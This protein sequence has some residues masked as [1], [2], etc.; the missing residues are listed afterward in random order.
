MEDGRRGDTHIL[1]MAMKDDRMPSHIRLDFVKK[2]YGIL[3]AMLMVS[4]LI[5]SPFVFNTEST[6][7]VMRNY[8]WIQG[9]CVVI[10]LAHN[11]VNMAIAFEQ[12]CGGGACTR[13]Y[14]KMF[15]TTPWNYIFLFTYAA[16]FGVVLGIVCTQYKASSVGLVF[17]LTAG[18]MAA[19]SVYAVKTK[20]DFTGLG[21]YFFVA[22]CGLLLLGLVGMFFPYGSFF[23]K[24]MAV[25]GAVIFSFVIIYDTQLIFGTASFEFNR[26]AVRNIQFTVDMYAF[27]AYQLYLDFINMFLYLLSLFGERRD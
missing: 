8:P 21:M 19:L 7:L 5:V 9:L 4:F 6:M 25:G 22:L 2:V 20:T 16:C 15:K 12:C 14:F 18:L 13:T 23:H 26:S 17:L 3:T 10:L 1:E 27:A 24:M 11:L